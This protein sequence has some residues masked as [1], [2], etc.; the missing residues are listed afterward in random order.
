[1]EYDVQRC[2]RRCASSG[3]ELVPGEEF[4]SVL[5]D[6]GAELKRYDFSR[7]AWQG[8]PEGAIGWWKTQVPSPEAKR[9]HWAPNDLML[10]VFEQLESQPQR[11]DLRY[12]L[13]LLLV[14]RRVLRLEEE[15]RDQSGREWLVV[16]CPR[17]DATYRVPAVAPDEAKIEA[18]QDE[19]ARL[20]FGGGA[21]FQPA[22]EQAAG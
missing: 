12:L 10:H 18:I 6:E 15:E 7:E 4:F 9:P 8:P 13:G 19:L 11:A 3:R 22:Q 14:R 21:G 17:R 5:V 20:L 2:T 1:M 16:Y